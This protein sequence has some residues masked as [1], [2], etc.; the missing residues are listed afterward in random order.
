MRRF[1][2]IFTLLMAIGLTNCYYE[3][4]D[5]E[6]WGPAVNLHVDN[7]LLTFQATEGNDTIPVECNYPTWEV[8]VTNNDSPVDWCT[9]KQYGTKLVV[10][11]SEHNTVDQRSA[12]VKISAGRGDQT[13]DVEIVVTQLGTAP[14]IVTDQSV[15][16]FRR[17]ND[18]MQ[19][20]VTTN[21]SS[22]EIDNI[23]SSWCRAR[24]S[25]ADL[26]NI[27]VDDNNEEG[28]RSVLIYLKASGEDN[29]TATV[30][31]MVYQTGTAEALQPSDPALVFESP[32]GEKSLTVISSDD[33]W[34]ATPAAGASW[35]RLVPDG[36]RLAVK[37]DQ[38]NSEGSRRTEITL[39][40]GE[41]T[42]TVSVMQLGSQKELLVA[43]EQLEFD[44]DAGSKM[45]GVATNMGEWYFDDLSSSDWLTINQKKNNLEIAVKQ[46]P[47]NMQ[48]RSARVN[49]STDKGAN[50][51]VE[52]TQLP[53]IT[54][55]LS[56]D[57]EPVANLIDV[58]V[59]GDQLKMDISTDQAQWQAEVKE[60]GEECS[61]CSLETGPDYVMIKALPNTGEVNREAV[62]TITAGSGDYI[63][64]RNVII[65]Q[66]TTTDRDILVAFYEATGG[67]NWKKNTN[68][69]SNR[70]LSEWYG[71]TVA[72]TATGEFVSLLELSDNG[73]T[74]TIPASMG[75]LVM[76]S[77][78]DLSHNEITGTIPGELGALTKL[79]T[80]SLGSNKFTGVLLGELG[81]LTGLTYLG[82]EHNNFDEQSLPDWLPD[83]TSLRTLVLSGSNFT[84]A[85]LPE[86][87]NLTAL[88]ELYLHD[89]NFTG[90]V[91][92]EF[93]R[94]TNLYS[95]TLSGNKL[96]GSV[97]K[98][99]YSLA[100]WESFQP[101]TNI[102]PQQDGEQ[103]YL[104]SVADREAL[105]AIFEA[106][107][108]KEWTNKTGW[109]TD[110][111]LSEW[112]G[113]SC[114]EEDRV[115]GLSLS[116]NEVKGTIPA[117]IGKLTE[118]TNLQIAGYSEITDTIPV[119]ITN[120]TKL[121]YLSFWGQKLSGNL[122]AEIGN[123]TE[124]LSLRIPFN[125]LEGTLPVELGNLTKLTELVLYNNRFTG[126][127][128]A[129]LRDLP[130]WSNFDASTNIVPQQENY[131]FVIGGKT[132]V[133]DWLIRFFDAMGGSSWTNKTNWCTDE[134]LSAWY[135]VTC[136]EDGDLFRL[137]LPNN[138]LTGDFPATIGEMKQLE[139]LDLSRN[140]LTGSLPAE[141]TQL[142][143]LR[144]C[145]L[146][147][148]QLSGEIPAGFGQLTKLW[149]L[150]LSNNQFSGDIRELCKLT[151]L[152]IL[153]LGNNLFS[154]TIPEEIGNMSTTF[155]QWLDLKN[156]NFT[157]KVPVVISK[158]TGLQQLN[159]S[160]NRFGGTFPPELKT[161]PN[162]NNFDADVNIF[163]QQ[164]GY[165]F[166]ASGESSGDNFEDVEW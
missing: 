107:G 1:F 63:K 106:L 123:L 37:I 58:A 148:N 65:R 115:T 102:L 146:Q 101:E 61:W 26:L 153:F 71:V 3:E 48:A 143:G 145:D 82:L 130:N 120:L 154:G 165:G 108:G 41:L 111:P 15:L 112:Y 21:L 24:K 13:G 151:K 69:C 159:L 8:T 62:L 92:A 25:S 18:Q 116:Y 34:T 99:V 137:E 93:S 105:L 128:P 104:G 16:A 88:R 11:V 9:A 70:P 136:T 163:P 75:G 46:N 150:C 122:P 60:N 100:N 67:D 68:W 39:S 134:P 152:E 126:E 6:T 166:T 94:L 27:E 57:K 33:Q 12:T 110:R 80:L 90:S 54:L 164:S 30:S 74:G 147:Q 28:I 117:E 96:S 4:L 77:T 36:N 72:S 103:L 141:F 125:N 158:L 40:S 23:T 35:C 156:N 84:G 31:I 114:N 121:Q 124:L 78:L 5:P 89:N 10:H 51:T 59:L 45:I 83:L 47:S 127:I 149:N 79:H 142:T 73:L 81:Q 98:T 29:K 87:G 64:R 95:L 19:L 129:E 49:I 38:N 131:G 118:L 53:R 2:W 109:N 132:E 160:G 55:D 7:K 97:P 161:L 138:N 17:D 32:A 113:V 139:K 22:W 91:P 85:L 50:K 42:N 44:G 162:W 155:F 43:P 66:S 157:G 56:V 86:L 119:E 76:L 52:I 140:Q 144:S 20:Y 133:R 14:A 135:G